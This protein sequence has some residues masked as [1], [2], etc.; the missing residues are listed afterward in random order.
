MAQSMIGKLYGG[1]PLRPRLKFVVVLVCAA[2]LLMMVV[3]PLK[4]HTWNAIVTRGDTALALRHYAEARVEYTKLRLIRPRSTEPAR[5]ID[6][7]NK[8][9]DDVL[10]LR[11]F[12]E[13][14]GDTRMLETLDQVTRAYDTPAQATQA[15]QELF[16]TL[17]LDLATVCITKTT[18]TWPMFKDAWLT[19]RVI[20]K[21]SGNSELE[22][23]S[24]AKIIELDP[25]ATSL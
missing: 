16:K 15:C 17:E 13:A 9:E 4:N 20:A 22:Q 7:V 14:R 8:A 12:Y 25:S 23:R 6:R 5:L 3:Q 2:I 24:A 11:P 1:I 18:T 21:A 10:T 19:A